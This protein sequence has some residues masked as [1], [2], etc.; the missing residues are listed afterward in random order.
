LKEKTREDF[1]KKLDDD[2]LE[3]L[4][5]ELEDLDVFKSHKE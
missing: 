3:A 1:N 2:D 4:M 5:D